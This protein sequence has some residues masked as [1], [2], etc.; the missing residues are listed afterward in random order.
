MIP[1]LIP[2]PPIVGAQREINPG[3]ISWVSSGT[4]NWSVPLF[5]NLFITVV[6]AGGGGS[7][8]GYT[9]NYVL[10]PFESGTLYTGGAGGTGG[11]GQFY[12]PGIVNMVAYGGVGGPGGSTYQTS[13][14]MA[15]GSH[16]TSVGGNVSNQDGAGGAG[17]V[18]GY[19]YCHWR[20]FSRI[21]FDHYGYAYGGNGGNG[22]RCD[23][24]FTFGQ[25]ALGTVA[26]IVVQGVGGAG[27]QASNNGGAYP[28]NGGGAGVHVSWN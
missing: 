22:G 25:V 16:G 19:A 18:Y 23:G 27:Y 28:T 2:A 12:I 9:D 8:S 3:S 24:K 11:Y 26:T 14:P 13:A 1:G 10:P 15:Q 17:G 7:G 21:Y 20:H 6:G 4:F 5:N